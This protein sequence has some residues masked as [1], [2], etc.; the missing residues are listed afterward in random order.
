MLFWNVFPFVFVFSCLYVGIRKLL[1]PL[2]IVLCCVWNLFTN[3][4]KHDT[5]STINMIVRM[6]TTTTKKHS[7]II[8][9]LKLNWIYIM[10]CMWIY[11]FEAFIIHSHWDCFMFPTPCT[12]PHST[13]TITCDLQLS[14]YKT[15]EKWQRKIHW[16]VHCDFVCLFV[17]CASNLREL[18]PSDVPSH[19][20]HKLY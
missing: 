14:F 19:K 12:L 18:F 3:F 9:K 7:K 16:L 11:N 15:P 8:W 4:R 1:Y 13:H 6:T 17:I 5:N 10:W 2:C 20:T